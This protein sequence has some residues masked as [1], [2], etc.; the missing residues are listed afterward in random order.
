MKTEVK[1][2]NS[3]SYAE[4]AIE[5]EI[6]RQITALEAGEEIVQETPAGGIQ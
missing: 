6:A 4:K 2:I 1:N 3:F 5:Y